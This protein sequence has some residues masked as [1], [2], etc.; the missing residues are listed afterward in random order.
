MEPMKIGSLPAVAMEQYHNNK[1]R[2]RKAEA[3]PMAADSVELSGAARMFE[4]AL[5]AVKE[6]PEVRSDRVAAI[7]AQVAAGT[8]KVDAAAIAAK[9]LAGVS[10]E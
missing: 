6:S 8:Y 10:L 7:S 2:T 4:K 1:I 9:M 3:A 5:A